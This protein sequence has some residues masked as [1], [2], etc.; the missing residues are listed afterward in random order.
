MKH[1]MSEH[2][3]LCITT[4]KIISDLALCP[5]TALRVVA[6]GYDTYIYNM[7]ALNSSSNGI[8]SGL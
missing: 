3:R 2:V 1:R 7:Q 4:D 6:E 5:P 8:Q